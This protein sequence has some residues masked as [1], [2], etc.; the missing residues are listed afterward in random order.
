MRDPGFTA[1]YCAVDMSTAANQS[2]VQQQPQNLPP[3]YNI[4][5]TDEKATREYSKWHPKSW[6][7]NT[8]RAAFFGVC[9][10]I[11][12]IICGAYF[13]VRANKYPNYNKLNYTLRD[14]Y[15][16]SDF[17]DRFEYFTGYD[18]TSGFV[19]YVDNA[20]ASSMNLTYASTERAILRVDTSEQSATTGRKSVRITSKQTYDSGL[21]IFDIA[22]TPYGCG[23]WPAVWLS[24]PANWPYN[25]EI[26]VVEAVN[27]V[28]HGQVQ[29]TLHTTKNCD[30]NRKRKMSGTNIKSNC[31]NG[32]NDNAGCGV[33]GE[34]NT[35]GAG[36][37]AAGG[38]VYAMEWRDAGI[39]IWFFDRNSLPSDLSAAIDVSGDTSS[40]SNSTTAAP[41]PSGWGEAMAD[42]PGTNC[43]ISSHFRN[44][45]IIANIDL[46]GSWAGTETVYNGLDSC[47]GTCTDYVATNY[48]AFTNAYW[49]FNSFRVFQAE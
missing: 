33:Y 37:N 41:D 20:T 11:V 38:G 42:F 21:F 35:F 24:D 7:K 14:T 5:Y 13:G 22:H 46:C 16:G 44:Q 23:T 32:T 47:P 34:Q 28:P 2:H 43:D 6:G 18:P 48:S 45:S 8:K 40:S 29:M 27:S 17:F 9:A 10:I 25:G 19:H 31:Y 30:M 15:S 4:D 49:E 36:F 26:D 12:A 1:S 3:P 39:R